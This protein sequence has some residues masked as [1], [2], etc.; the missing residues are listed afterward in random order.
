MSTKDCFHDVYGSFSA[1]TVE[2]D[3]P[4]AG[5]MSE[6]LSGLGC[7]LAKQCVAFDHVGLCSWRTRQRVTCTGLAVISQWLFSQWLFS[8][9]PETQPQS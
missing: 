8:H 9:L 1:T 5:E 3:G 6:C 7:I 2:C 4:N